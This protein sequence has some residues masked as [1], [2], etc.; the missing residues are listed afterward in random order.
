[1]VRDLQKWIHACGTNNAWRPIKVWILFFSWKPNW[2]IRKALVVHQY[3]SKPLNIFRQHWTAVAWQ[4]P[5]G[6]WLRW[7]SVLCLSLWA[8]SYL[9]LLVGCQP[10]QMLRWFMISPLSEQLFVMEHLSTRRKASNLSGER[11]GRKAKIWITTVWSALCPYT[12]ISHVPAWNDSKQ[13]VK[14]NVCDNEVISRSHHGFVKNK[15]S[16]LLFEWKFGLV[17]CH[18]L[19]CVTVQPEHS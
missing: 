14:W 17:V 18:P 7:T 1:M 5:W 2:I 11:K 19:M 6:V 16:P 4:T 15:S 13:I 12:F 8:L 10:I 3:Y 9:L